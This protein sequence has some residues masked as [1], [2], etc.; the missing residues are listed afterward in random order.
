MQTHVKVE[1]ILSPPHG[2]TGNIMF[3]E[4]NFNTRAIFFL[5]TY[6]SNDKQNNSN[7]ASYIVLKFY[8]LT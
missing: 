4:V 2:V 1:W 7:L 8:A 6:S 3:L 5:F